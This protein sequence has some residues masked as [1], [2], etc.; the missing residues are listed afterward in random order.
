MLNKL[1][2]LNKDLKIYSIHDD[3][4]KKYGKVIEFDSAEFVKFWMVIAEFLS[5]TLLSTSE[6]TAIC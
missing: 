3:E 2:E 6:P 4:F 1:K 5:A